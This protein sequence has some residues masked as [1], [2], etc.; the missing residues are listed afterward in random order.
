MKKK[1]RLYRAVLYS[2]CPKGQT[3]AAYFRQ[4]CTMV[5]FWD[6]LADAFERYY[7][8]YWIE[9]F[10]ALTDRRLAGPLALN[11]QMSDLVQ[12]NRLR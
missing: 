11:E 12:C 5:G 9:I 8:N 4:S 6:D 2:T 1:V 3:G 7:Q 10:D